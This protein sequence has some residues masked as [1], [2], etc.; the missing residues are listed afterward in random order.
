MN[1]H[2]SNIPEISGLDHVAVEVNDMKEALEFYT[3]ILGLEEMQTPEEV[4]AKGVRWLRLPGN[5][6]LHIVETKDSTMPGTAHLAI[7]VEEVESWE[8]YLND[9]N[10]E[11]H[12]P[13]FDL[14]NAKRIFFR[15]PSGN[16]I[17]FVKWLE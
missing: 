13:K 4:K 12:P 10:I 8:K 14:Y 2:K 5:Q 15:D 7:I 1:T 6:A 3:S 16:R 9:H 11:T 17:E